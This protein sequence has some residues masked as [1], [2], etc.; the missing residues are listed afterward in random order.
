MAESHRRGQQGLMLILAPPSPVGLLLREASE[1]RRCDLQQV[2]VDT[3]HTQVYNALVD[4]VAVRYAAHID[5][6]S[7]V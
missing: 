4:G 6:H 1:G 7:F 5:A 3:C 2:S